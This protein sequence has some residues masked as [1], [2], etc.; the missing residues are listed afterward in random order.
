[1]PEMPQAVP[2]PDRPPLHLKGGYLA[3]ASPINLEE[4]CFAV[5]AVRALKRARPQGTLVVVSPE[6]IA[7]LWHTVRSV[8]QVLLYHQ[9]T[10]PRQLART[11]KDCGVPFD[12]SI[13]W[14]K[15][16]AALAFQKAGILQRLGPPSKDLAKLLTDPVPS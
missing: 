8:D 9:K 10:S 12:S 7:P 2:C 3:V 13:T 15:N 16:T 14:D 6:S 11:L 5:P 1:M 4:A